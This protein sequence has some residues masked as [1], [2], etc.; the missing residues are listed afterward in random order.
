MSSCLG[1]ASFRIL[2]TL[3]TI[4]VPITTGLTLSLTLEYPRLNAGTELP[5]RCII[6]LEARALEGEHDCRL[7]LPLDTG[8]TEEDRGLGAPGLP[9]VAESGLSG[10]EVLRFGGASSE[11]PGIFEGFHGLDFTVGEVPWDDTGFFDVVRAGLVAE[12]DDLTGGADTLGALDG[13][14][15]RRVGVD[16][17]DVD[18]DGGIEE[19]LEVGVEDLAVDLEGVEDLA[20]DLEGVE[21]L[22][23][24]LEGVEDLA[25]TVG[26]D[27]ETVGL[28]A[29][30]V[31]FKAEIEDLVAESVAF[32]V[33]S[34]G[35]VVETA[36]LVEESAGLVEDKVGRE[37]GVGDLEGFDDA[38][39][40][41][42]PVGVEGLDP[43]PPDDEGL[44]TPVLEIFNPGEE[45]GCL[46]AKLLRTGGSG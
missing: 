19:G 10:T 25:G 35:F 34:V 2:I 8:S 45:A 30:T 27:A 42:R 32:E 13:V 22:V 9:L 21:D 11:K 31:G 15:G 17:L 7:G 39:N 23:V 12:G 29:E 36:G 41:E 28:D 18:F 5:L 24:D 37:V 6:P 14:D 43:G 46:D 3:S 20:V 44:R 4:F 38:V 1:G 16:A 33:E 40:V 26:L